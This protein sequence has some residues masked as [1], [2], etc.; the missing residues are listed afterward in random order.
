MHGSDFR[1]F[2]LRSQGLSFSFGLG[3]PVIFGPRGPQRPG[4]SSRT[5]ARTGCGTPLGSESGAPSLSSSLLSLFNVRPF[6]SFILL[7]LPCN[8][9]H[10]NFIKFSISLLFCGVSFL[11]CNTLFMS[12]P[13]TFPSFILASLICF[14]LLRLCNWRFT[15]ITKL[16]W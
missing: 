2:V 5:Q 13:Q 4:Y 14:T 9:I 12:S 15:S 8:F 11:C 16:L 7:K 3:T 10:T 6:V 1:S